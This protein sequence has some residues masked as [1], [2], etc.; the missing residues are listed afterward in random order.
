MSRAISVITTFPPNKWNQYAKRMLET[1]DQNWPQSITLKVYYEG[2]MPTDAPQS[3]RIQWIDLHKACPDLVAFKD[4]HKDNP[5]ANGFK[6][7]SSTDQK[8]SFLFE[9]VRF[10]HKSFC[11]SHETL[12]SSTE[13]VIWLDADVVTH[14]A[15]P[16]EFIESL[17]P[18][19]FYTAYL[20]RQKI[21]PECGFVIYNTQHPQ[22]KK[23]MTAWQHLYN[24]DELFELEEYHDSYLFWHLLKKHNLVDQSFNIS[25][26]HPHRPG[27][28]VFIN[29]P[30]GQYMDH[31]KG[32]RKKQ[33]ISKKSD[34]YVHHNSDYWKKL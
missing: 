19:N 24:N 15:I 14:S 9:A 32:S 6:V 3:D 12:N 34:I 30:L 13:L 4:K 28:H 2:S 23:F 22:H 7:G 1:F 31:L 5:Y 20:G 17:L 27:V 10:A 33:G 21:Y 11:V 18:Q 16:L 29:S 26:G 25:E 8:G